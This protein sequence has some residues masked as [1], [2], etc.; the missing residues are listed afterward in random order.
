MRIFDSFIRCEDDL[1][2]VIKFYKIECLNCKD[3]FSEPIVSP[4]ELSPPEGSSGQLFCKEIPNSRE[5]DRYEWHK[6]S[7]NDDTAAT[8]T[9]IKTGPLL[10]LKNMTSVD[11][12]WYHCCLYYS[13]ISPLARAEFIFKYGG[14]LESYDGGSIDEFDMKKE[15]LRYCASSRVE[16]KTSPVMSSNK[17]LKTR[18]LMLIIVIAFLVLLSVMILLVF[19]CYSRLK[20]MKH[21]QK[22][23][24][25]MKHV[26]LLK[27]SFY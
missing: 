24:G 17:L 5:P 1:K 25:T 21:A 20:L 15:Y 16:V 6:I 13:P 8:E 9:K 7:L 10:D 11:S 14:D 18:Q 19:C 12:G 26:R 3:L 23:M 2:N 22:A 27:L 4:D